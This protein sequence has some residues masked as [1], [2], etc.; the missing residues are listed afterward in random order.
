MDCW[1]EDKV[2]KMENESVQKPF[3]ALEQEINRVNG[4]KFYK[5]HLMNSVNESLGRKDL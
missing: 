4:P 2:S 1:A 3:S 5:K